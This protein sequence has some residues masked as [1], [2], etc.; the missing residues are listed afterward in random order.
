M[1]Y[2]HDT[3]ELRFMLKIKDIST[4]K[5]G[6]TL[7]TKLWSAIDCKVHLFC[8]ICYHFFLWST[9]DHTHSATMFAYVPLPTLEALYLRIYSSGP[10]W[11]VVLPGKLSDNSSFSSIGSKEWVYNYLIL[12]TLFALP[13]H[14]HSFHVTMAPPGHDLITVLCTEI[15]SWWGIF[16]TQM[17]VCDGYGGNGTD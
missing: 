14:L 8:F 10:C 5:Q 12:I 7:E 2:H 17:F 4:I 1:F 15:S 11:K 16:F 6:H 3:H 9:T 13:S